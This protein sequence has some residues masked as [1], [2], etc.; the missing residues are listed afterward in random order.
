MADKIF[1]QLRWLLALLAFSVICWASVIVICAKY[2]NSDALIAAIS[3][4]AIAFLITGIFLGIEI[5]K[6]E[7]YTEH[8]KEEEK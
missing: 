8:F 1:I 6:S 2:F 4:M 3:I 5:K 7:E